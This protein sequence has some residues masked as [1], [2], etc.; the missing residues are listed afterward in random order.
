MKKLLFGLIATVMFGFVGNAQSRVTI[1]LSRNTLSNNVSG[2]IKIH[3][4]IGR[5]RHDCLGIWICKGTVDVELGRVTENAMFQ[6]D[7]KN[8]KAILY[9]QNSGETDVS[10][11]IFE[12]EGEDYVSFGKFGT[13]ISKN[14]EL[15]LKPVKIDGILYNYVVVMDLE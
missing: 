3:L 1:P 2:K 15:V 4:E 7:S 11:M 5:P 8:K 14:Y 10:K 13:I 12:G 6:F 9:I